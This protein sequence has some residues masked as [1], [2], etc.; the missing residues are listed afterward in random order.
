MFILNISTLI[1]VSQTWG[2]VVKATR[3]AWWTHSSLG[4]TASPDVV[5]NN[6]LLHCVTAFGTKGL[7][8]HCEHQWTTF[9]PVMQKRI[10]KVACDFYYRHGALKQENSSCLSYP[11]LPSWH[12]KLTRTQ[13]CKSAP[14]VKPQQPLAQ[15]CV[16]TELPTYSIARLNVKYMFKCHHGKQGKYKSHCDKEENRSGSIATLYFLTVLRLNHCCVLTR[17]WSKKRAKLHILLHV[18]HTAITVTLS[19]FVFP[20]LVLSTSSSLLSHSHQILRYTLEHLGSVREA[21]E[22]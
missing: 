22:K 16:S 20:F 15:H 19:L 18:K 10:S 3:W 21:S 12:H 14:A 2:S 7:G 17:C 8:L 5:G 11:F 6:C 9:M 1:L 13:L 4:Y